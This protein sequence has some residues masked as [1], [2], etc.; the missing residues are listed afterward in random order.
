MWLS[1]WSALSKRPLL[2]HE[3]WSHRDALALLWWGWRGVTQTFLPSSRNEPHLMAVGAKLEAERAH[4]QGLAENP[5]PSHA[6]PP[7]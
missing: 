1:K 7:R 6:I 3:K 4:A 5:A 2:L